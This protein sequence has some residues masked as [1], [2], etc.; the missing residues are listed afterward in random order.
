M[1]LVILLF[2]IYFVLG[3]IECFFLWYWFFL[4]LGGFE[5]ND[6]KFWFVNLNL[7]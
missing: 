2:D 1:V 5:N 3:L 7:M 4:R 6:K